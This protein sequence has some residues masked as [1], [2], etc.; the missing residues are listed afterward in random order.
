MK[1]AD[2]TYR[3]KSEEEMKSIIVRVLQVCNIVTVT[4]GQ[5]KLTEFNAE[6]FLF[7]ASLFYESIFLS[8][9]IFY[10]MTLDVLRHLCVGFIMHWS[11][12]VLVVNT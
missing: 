4:E 2:F 9:I 12:I 8:K 10:K 5:L 1:R 3:S 7:P 11:K 6:L